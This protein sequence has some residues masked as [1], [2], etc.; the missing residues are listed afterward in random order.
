MCI[1]DSLWEA[2][3]DPG[4]AA[5]WIAL[6][7]AAIGVAFAARPTVLPNAAILLIPFL[8][9]ETRRS[10]RAWAAAVVPLALC[11]AG[12]ALYNAERFGNPFDFGMR[13]QLAAINVTKLHA[14]SPTYIWTNLGF[15]LF[16]EVRWTSIFPRCV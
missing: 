13:Y 9:R 6:A 5:K 3:G 15:Y 4:R 8:S 1:R 11:G 12:V 16:Q 14:F 7:S 10:A 2:Y